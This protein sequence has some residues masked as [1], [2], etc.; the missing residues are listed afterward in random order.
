M[1]AIWLKVSVAIP[2]I[3]KGKVSSNPVILHTLIV[4]IVPFG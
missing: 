1:P 4:R 2:F 3:L